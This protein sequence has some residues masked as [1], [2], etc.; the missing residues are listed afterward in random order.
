MMILN[1]SKTKVLIF[2]TRKWDKF[3]IKDTYTY[4]GFIVTPSG[5]FTACIK[6]LIMKTKKAYNCFRFKMSPQ[7]G[8]PINVLLNVF[9]SLVS[10]IAL[11]GAKIWGLADVKSRNN[12]GAQRYTL[13]FA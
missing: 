12:N 3:V 1:T 6:N 5:K 2:N 4:L 11:Y 8:C 13:P 7:T 10:P 9:N